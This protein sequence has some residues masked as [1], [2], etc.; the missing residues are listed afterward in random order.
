VQAA[1]AR[2]REKILPTPVSHIQITNLPDKPL[3][4]LG[5]TTKN[6]PAVLSARILSGDENYKRLYSREGWFPPVYVP[7]AL[8][9]AEE[10]VFR[11]LKLYNLASIQNIL[12]NGLEYDRVATGMEDKIYFSGGVYRAAG[13]ITWH[14]SKYSPYNV[15]PTLVRLALPA[16]RSDIYAHSILW[17]F[18]YYYQVRN[19]PAS[20]IQDVMVFLEV[21][22]KPDWYKVTLEDG[23]L[24]FTPAHSRVFEPA[25]LIEH[26][27][28]IPE[29]NI[30]FSGE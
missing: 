16:D 14:K 29:T 1:L 25:E 23:E 13:Y 11:G 9:T 30:D 10:S 20:Y 8:N 18:D 2:T 24:I 7:E 5:G 12:T 17:A 6:T 19:I 26:N 28:N 3:V 15:I 21:D 22:G 27:I 4:K